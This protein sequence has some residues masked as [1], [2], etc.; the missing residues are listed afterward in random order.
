MFSLWGG[1]SELQKKADATLHQL[2][3]VRAELVRSEAG[4][5]RLRVALADQAAEGQERELELRAM[6]LEL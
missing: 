4:R 6:E 2:N 5:Q 1:S 3:A